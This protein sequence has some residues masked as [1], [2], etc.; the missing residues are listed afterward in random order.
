M[1]NFQP[2]FSRGTTY[3][4]RLFW[5]KFDFF[6]IFLE[7]SWIIYSK[8]YIEKIIFTLHTN[9]Y[10]KAIWKHYWNQKSSKEI[11]RFWSRK[12]NQFW[13]K[14]MRNFLI[15]LTKLSLKIYNHQNLDHNAGQNFMRNKS[16]LKR[17]KWPARSEKHILNSISRF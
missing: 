8:F 13:R 2:L 6:E 11:L 9:F 10:A 7:F 12:M 3:H 4:F 5:K 1:S 14:K 17:L 15:S 16:R